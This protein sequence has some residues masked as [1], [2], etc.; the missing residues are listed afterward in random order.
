MLPSIQMYY[1][2]MSRVISLLRSVARV[3]IPNSEGSLVFLWGRCGTVMN[4]DLNSLVVRWASDVVHPLIAL[5]LSSNIFTSLDSWM[6]QDIL[7]IKC[8]LCVRSAIPSTTRAYCSSTSGIVIWY[9]GF[10]SRSISTQR[11]GVYT[12]CRPQVWS[13]QVP[14]VVCL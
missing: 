12:D 8:I 11:S 1:L 7:C 10:I 9:W 3:G 4:M 13:P 5:H 6:I 2:V 14:C